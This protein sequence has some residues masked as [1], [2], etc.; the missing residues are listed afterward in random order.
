M[1]TFASPLYM[2]RAIQTTRERPFHAVSHP[3]GFLQRMMK[4]REPPNVRLYSI[5][6]NKASKTADTSH[7]RTN[8]YTHVQRR[9]LSLDGKLHR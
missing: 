9:W 4:H 3:S 8:V 5:N 1:Q 7:T 2:F 6:L